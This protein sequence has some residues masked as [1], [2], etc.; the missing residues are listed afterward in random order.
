MIFHVY[1][2]RN[3]GQTIFV[4]AVDRALFETI[5]FDVVRRYG[6]ILHGY[7]LMGNH[8]HLIVEIRGGGSLSP[9]MQRLNGVYAQAFNRRHGFSG[10]LFQGRFK[11]KEITSDAQLLQLWRY[12]GYNPVRAGLCSRPEE[13]PWSGIHRLIP[14]DRILGFFANDRQRALLA[15]RRFLTP[16]EPRAGP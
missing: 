7:V 12:L 16:L 8:Y 2:R 13:W 3:R 14:S 6:W 1:S 15:L 9:G 11:S 10:H 5:L 4:D